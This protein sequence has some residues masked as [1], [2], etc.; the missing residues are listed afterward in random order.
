MCIPQRWFRYKGRLSDIFPVWIILEGCMT[1]L[2]YVMTWDENRLGIY[3]KVHVSFFIV[4]VFFRCVSIKTKTQYLHT[5]SETVIYSSP[6]KQ[7]VEFFVK[8]KKIIRSQTTPLLLTV[9]E[10]PMIVFW[11]LTH[12]SRW[13]LHCKNVQI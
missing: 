11:N 7:S 2:K 5:G 4:I 10:K 6:A 8:L 13:A 12:C 9:T 3:I 1:K